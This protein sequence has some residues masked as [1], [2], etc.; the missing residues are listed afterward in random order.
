MK[1]TSSVCSCVR[2]W[3]IVF[4]LVCSLQPLSARAEE[5]V[6]SASNLSAEAQA[7][8]QGVNQERANAGLPPLAV[9]PLLNQ[10]AQ[11]H[12]DD[13]INNGMYGHMG[14]DGS[15]AG[16]RVQRVG[17][18]AGGFA[19]ENWV[20]SGSVAGAMHWW[21]NDWIHRVNILNPRWREVGIGASPSSGGQWIFVTVFTAGQG[22]GPEPVYA[23]A[24]PA[25]SQAE[26][27]PVDGL[28]YTISPGDT[29][30]G[31]AARYGID[32][33]I[34][35]QSNRLGENDL[36]QIGQVIRLP[37]VQEVAELPPPVPLKPIDEALMSAIPVTSAEEVAEAAEEVVVEEAV[38]E[39]AS[40]IESAGYV[41]EAGDTLL[42]IAI[43]NNLT[44]EELAAANNLGEDDLLQIG[45]ALTIPGQVAEPQLAVAALEDAPAAETAPIAVV[46]EPPP[47]NNNLV[48]AKA[49]VNL[50]PTAVAAVANEV[51]ADD[52]SADDAQDEEEQDEEDEDSES[53]DDAVVAVAAIEQDAVEEEAVVSAAAAPAERRT[54]TIEA[55]E[56]IISVAVK[57]GLDWNELLAFNGL[58]ENSVLQI[59]Q[60]IT[61][62]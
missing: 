58:D 4:C 34:I 55:G 45:Q 23:A 32:W 9:H 47:A 12:V 49:E 18:S 14:S 31:V 52:E 5:T 8:A 19:S 3:V 11:G 1:R 62:P 29:L 33:T 50:A 61:L 48:F 40:T 46:A 36:L 35:A 27:L 44:W 39:A 15:Y 57:Y 2:V 13:M 60:E 56:T 59:G 20:S 51:E 7:I 16:Q 30:I 26:V 17:Y 25:Q 6:A 37:G 54:H 10:A 42:S 43:R 38:V 41:V 53:S 28:D 21:M 24:A 22:Q